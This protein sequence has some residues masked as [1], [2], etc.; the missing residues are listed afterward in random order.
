MYCLGM[1]LLFFWYLSL[2]YKADL[3]IIEKSKK[4]KKM[5][6]KGRSPNPLASPPSPLPLPGPALTWPSRG[7]LSSPHPAARLGPGGTSLLAGL[8]RP[9]PLAGLLVGPA[10]P[11]CLDPFDL[12]CTGPSPPP[13]SIRPSW[14][15]PRC[16][17]PAHSRR[18]RHAP[19]R[20]APVWA[21]PS[22][23]LPAWCRSFLAPPV[24]SCNCLL[25]L[26]CARV[27]LRQN[28]PLRA[29]IARPRPQPR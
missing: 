26:S 16:L 19:Q 25:F 5:E 24:I 1:H 23:T 9:P 12:P 3:E 17:V 18:P 8:A 15:G 14:L 27:Y 2:A 20:L 4:K 29:P 22:R 21:T 6:K 28:R 7:G 10:W 11:T 13:A